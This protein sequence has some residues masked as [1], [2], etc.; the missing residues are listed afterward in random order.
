MIANTK[1]M[2]ERKVE[3]HEVDTITYNKID[4]P[5]LPIVLTEVIPEPE[6]T[7][8]AKRRRFTAQYKLDILKQVD[9]LYLNLFTEYLYL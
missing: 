8:K 1:K 5:A 3:I 6:V 7:T 4:Q 2:A 9:Y